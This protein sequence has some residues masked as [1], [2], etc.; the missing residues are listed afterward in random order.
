MVASGDLDCGPY[1]TDDDGDSGSAVGGVGG[2]GGSA[3]P[4]RR[5]T[6]AP[7]AWGGMSE[8]RPTGSNVADS[9][10]SC[11]KRGAFYTAGALGRHGSGSGGPAGAADVSGGGVRGDAGF[12][13]RTSGWNVE[14]HKDNGDEDDDEEEEED[15][16]DDDGDDEMFELEVSALPGCGGGGCGLRGGADGGSDQG[17]GDHRPTDV[18]SVRGEGWGHHRF[19]GAPTTA[20]PSCD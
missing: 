12:G 5:R 4:W 13:N 9:E 10:S 1:R 18:F 6:S 3:Q 20:F 2:G 17:L 7:S 15:D 14:G 16:D 8:D 11:E 19:D